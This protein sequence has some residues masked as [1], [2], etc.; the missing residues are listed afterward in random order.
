MITYLRKSIFNIDNCDAIVNPVN[1]EGFMGAGLAYEFSLRY[2]KILEEYKSDCGNGNL[3]IGRTTMF[4]AESIKIINFP[5]KDK[6]KFPSTTKYIEEGL[7]YFVDNY[8]KYNIKSIG[9]P[10]LG[11]NNGGLNFE[12]DVKPLMEKYLSDIDLDVM[13]C[14]D[15]GVAEGKEKEMLDLYKSISPYTYQ[16]E[17]KIK[18]SQIEKLNNNR[19][20]INR[21]FEIL[22]IDGIGKTTYEKLFKYF[23]NYNPKVSDEQLSLF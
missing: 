3:C 19:N 11:C 6:F 20:N 10:L 5:T 13:I 1:C 7:I 9:F 4:N 21:F 17:L 14:I 2:P 16:K 23:Y 15:P 8:K 12:I 22:K 18:Y